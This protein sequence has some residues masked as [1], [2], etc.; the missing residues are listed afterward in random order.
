MSDLVGPA[1]LLGQ[2]T[3]LRAFAASLGSDRVAS[4][5]L[6]HGPDG[7][8]RSVGARIFAG[9]LLCERAKELRAC[10]ACASCRR[11]AAGAHPDLLWVAADSGPR[12][13][14]DD[15]AAR[16]GPE[17]FTRAA[18]LAAKRG[19]RRTIAVRTIRRLLELLSLAAAAGGRKVAVLDSFDEIEEEG[20]ATLLKS[21]EEPPPRTSFLLLA[22]GTAG[23]PDTILSRCQRVRFRPLAP[24]LVREL[25]RRGDAR[26]V[27]PDEVELLVRIAQGSAGRALR[28][29]EDGLQRDAV[30]AARA[31]LDGADPAAL[32]AAQA[33]VAA[34]G[35]ELEA[36]RERLRAFLALVLVLLRDGWHEGSRGGVLL[37]AVRAGFESADANVGAPLVLHGLWARAAR[38]RGLPV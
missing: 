18:R 19:P 1:S 31:L 22:R 15:E 28:A 21:L 9:A 16:A 30:P 32:P 37:A 14:D 38:A 34:A 23:I 8:G 20:T 25:L 7:V 13:D 27:P 5:Y 24:D 35:R 17:Q 10:G 26:D 36:Q 3:A 12:F 6:L 2:E 4:A 29:A 11:L 33:W